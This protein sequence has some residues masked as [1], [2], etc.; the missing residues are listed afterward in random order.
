MMLRPYVVFIESNTS[1]TGQ[2]FFAAAR[3]LNFEPILL[4]KDPQK[5]AFL[6]DTEIGVID[7]DTSDLGNLLSVCAQLASLRPVAGIMTSSEYFVEMV[8]RLTQKLSFSGPSLTAVS[9]CRNKGALRRA[10][11]SA[12]LETLRFSEIAHVDNV[13]QAVQQ[14]GLPVVV[15]PIAGSGSISVRLCLNEAE[16]EEQVTHIFRT[17]SSTTAL[18]EEYVSGT[19]YS[20]EVFNGE[21]VGITRKHLGKEPFFVETGHDFPAALAPDAK[22]DILRY[23]REVCEEIGLDWG[24]VHI[25]V[26]L[27]QKSRPQ[28][29][30]INPRLAGGFIPELVR[31]ASGVNLVEESVRLSTGLGRIPKVTRYRFASIQFLLP[32]RNGRISHIDGISDAWDSPNVFAVRLYK[33]LPLEVELRGDFRDRIGHVITLA[34]TG[35]KASE[36][37]S[38]ALHMISPSYVETDEASRGGKVHECA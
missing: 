37:A 20:V 34:E 26:K 19:E 3:D 9:M 38:A 2:L 10:L 27:D 16:A 30:E 31:L 33:P 4:A 25:E 24:A 8:A 23:V 5:Y 29:I 14:I 35:K 17:D 11:Q 21:P 32:E 1:G 12:G 7:C 13:R 22:N 36:A 28:I 6:A 18:L 15:K